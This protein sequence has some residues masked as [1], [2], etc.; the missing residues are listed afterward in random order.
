MCL[1]VLFQKI[2][3]IIRKIRNS[4]ENTNERNIQRRILEA[5]GK[6]TKS[7]QLEF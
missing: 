3:T 1:K 6:P 5:T 7:Y 4:I 2:K